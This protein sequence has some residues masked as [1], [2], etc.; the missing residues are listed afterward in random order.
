M[1]K[2][3]L[4]WILSRQQQCLHPFT[5]HHLS[6]TTPSASSTEV[7]K[8]TL[9]P[10]G[11]SGG[12][13]QKKYWKENKGDLHFLIPKCTEKQQQSQQDGTGRRT[14]KERKEAELRKERQI[15]P[16]TKNH[17]LSHQDPGVRTIQERNKVFSEQCWNN[18]IGKC[19]GKAASTPS[20]NNSYPN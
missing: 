10:H 12:W 3:L 13:Q 6:I 8:P 18:W 17:Q 5:K 20:V 19:R 4:F 2:H 1:G 15:N 14:A 16:H 11:V 7:G 9:N